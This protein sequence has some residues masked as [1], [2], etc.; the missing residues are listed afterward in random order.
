MALSQRAIGW[1][2]G[3]KAQKTAFLASPATLLYVCDAKDEAAAECF[4]KLKDLGYKA[5]Q[6]DGNLC[7]A[8]DP[9]GP[10]IVYQPEPVLPNRPTTIAQ[11]GEILAANN[12]C[13]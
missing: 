2:E 10:D 6:F 5:K 11:I 7:V 12:L 1:L 4:Q 9:Q 8:K 3:V 13:K